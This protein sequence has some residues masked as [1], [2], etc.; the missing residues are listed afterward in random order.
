[1]QFAVCFSFLWSTACPASGNGLSPAD[2]QFLLP[3]LHLFTDRISSLLL[4]L[5]LLQFQH[6]TPLLS[7]FSVCYSVLFGVGWI[8]L[9]WGCAS[10]CSWVCVG[11]CCMVCGAYLFVLSVGMHV[12]LEL[13]AAAARNGARF[14]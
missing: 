7:Q 8:S 13:G 1:L 11:D 6:S 3:L 14:S 2:S 9:L 12:G 4:P 10:L 5:C